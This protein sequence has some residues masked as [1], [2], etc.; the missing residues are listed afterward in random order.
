MTETFDLK[1]QGASVLIFG[2]L[3][4]VITAPIWL[5]YLLGTDPKKCVCGV[6]LISNEISPYCKCEYQ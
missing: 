1:T 5:P 4:I 2:A 6:Q 3:L